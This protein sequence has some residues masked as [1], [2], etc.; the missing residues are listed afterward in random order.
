MKIKRH[1]HPRIDYYAHGILVWLPN[2]PI[3]IAEHRMGRRVAAGWFRSL[4]HPQFRLQTL[5]AY[6]SSCFSRNTPPSELI[7]PT[8]FFF[9]AFARKSPVVIAL[10]FSS[11]KLAIGNL[12]I[13]ISCCKQRRNG[14]KILPLDSPTNC[15]SR[16]PPPT[17]GNG[18][19][20]FFF[21]SSTN[22]VGRPSY[23]L[24]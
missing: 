21:S 11:T 14:Y 7:F 24:L 9:V 22:I 10:H 16:R 15:P 13:K 6:C 8:I 12:Q 20:I 19:N 1:T 3:C 18:S 2:V 4:A 17:K 5:C 23:S